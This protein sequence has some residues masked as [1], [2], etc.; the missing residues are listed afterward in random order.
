MKTPVKSILSLFAGACC[1]LLV[2]CAGSADITAMSPANV[3]AVSRTGAPVQ[4]VVSGGTP[5]SEILASV[6]NEDFKGALETSL[7]KSGM[8]KSAANGGYRLDAFIASIDQPIMGFSMRVNMEVNYSLSRNGAPVWRKSI[9]SSYVAPVGEA[10]VGAIRLRKATEGAAREN[11]SLL[12]R[13]LDEK[14]L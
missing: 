4:A 7:V 8:F 9:R 13:A 2:S 14:R 1:C 3:S 12:I 10:F 11:I 5:R 6:T